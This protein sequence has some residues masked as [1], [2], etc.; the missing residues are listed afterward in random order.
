MPYIQTHGA[1]LVGDAVALFSLWAPDADSVA[2]E[3]ANGDIYPLQAGKEGWYRG[4]V[5]CG[6]GSCYRF[7]INGTL[8]V[9]DPASRAQRDDVH[10]FSCVTDHRSYPW[11]A[12]GW[13]GR[14]WH[15]SVIYE[16]HVG[17]LDGFS[18]VCSYLPYLKDLG[19]TAIELMPVGEF[20]GSRN[21]G[22]D[23]VLPYAPDSS[24]GS[25]ADLKHL[26]DTAHSLGLMIYLDVVYNHL[27]ADG[28]YL[29]QYASGFFRDDIDTPWGAAIDFRRPEVRNFFC[30]NAL[31]WIIDYRVDGLRLDAVHA[32]KEKDFL[33]E[34]A[35]R[36]R[37]A[38]GPD[39]HVHLI[40]ENEDNNASLLEHGYDAQW[41]DDGHNVLHT[42][43]TAEKSGYYAEFASD[44]TVKL[45]RF[46]KEGFIYQGE[47]TR[48]GT[49]RGEPSGHLAPTSF[50]LF[51]QNHDQVGNRA[52]GER[53]VTLADKDALKAAV[54][55]MLLSP[56]VPLLFMGEEWGT[57]QPF[58]FFTDH[59]EELAEAVREG[60]QN[61]LSDISP[62]A[63][64]TAG[65]TIPDPNAIDTFSSSR[66]Y[67]VSTED[68]EHQ[69]WRDWY[70][71]LLS[72]RREHI[73]PR[74]AKARSGGVTVLAEGALSACWELD[75]R[76]ILR[77]DIN[78]GQAAVPPRQPVAAD[79]ILFSYRVDVPGGPMSPGS[80]VVSLTESA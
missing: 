14:P 55:M 63:A 39:R 1:R 13:R 7:V 12:D 23:G 28:N 10:G 70:A 61:E 66:P 68:P 16:L 54:A 45:A 72:L 42:L 57:R 44:S 3:L 46:L 43:L 6:A 67:S 53:L 65:H 5:A 58:L 4:E 18:G 51:L 80:I 15:E 17:L 74:L 8:R 59:K 22:Y 75:D 36:V 50:V 77:I 56:M 71:G 35:R 69:S 49:R 47:P 21:W 30:E 40:L 29:H 27:G 52:F 26:I 76:S 33:V 19:I 37:G 73:T 48:E 25:P 24:Y 34:L 60:R 78:L 64:Q 2:V 9:P 20:P 31:M 62:F 38:A 79:D 11:S 32:I 41:N